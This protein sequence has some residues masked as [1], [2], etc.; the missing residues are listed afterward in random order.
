[1]LLKNQKACLES[2]GLKLDAVDLDPDHKLSVWNLC[3][4]RLDR[5]LD[6]ARTLD[7]WI[8]S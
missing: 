6:D 2:F 7:I 5:L 8:S 1:M 4:D 3:T